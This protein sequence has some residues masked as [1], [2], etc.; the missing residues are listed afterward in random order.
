MNAKSLASAV[1]LVLA[2][3]PAVAEPLGTGD[4]EALLDK[5][6]KLRKL[7]ESEQ[8]GRHG[9][10]RT[11]F[12]AAMLSDEGALDLYL[13]CIERVQFDGEQ[14]KPQEF[15]DWKRAEKEKLAD[16]GLA[17]AL[18]HQLRWLALTLDAAEAGSD[19]VAVTA[20]A[21]KAVDAVF[22]DAALLGGQAGMLRGSVLDSVFAKGYAVKGLELKD[23]PLSPSNLGE[24]Y[25]TLIL[26]PL[27][28]PEKLSELRS[29]WMSWIGQ[30]VLAAEHWGAGKK[31][32]AAGRTPA[33]ERFRAEDYPEMVWAMEEDLFKA[34]DEHAAAIN[35]LNQL[36]SLAKDRRASDWAR[37]FEALLRGGGEE[38]GPVPAKN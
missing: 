33:V 3:A 13:N 23:W 20:E 7:A 18:R 38:A 31:P 6:E 8:Q 11:A 24:V 27:R 19:R 35:M 22:A 29:A 10:A 21:R 37:R 17:R 26:P 14:K 4:R 36:E 25:A 9:V 1:M 2:A 34:G 12:R 15:R 30:S 28:K 16:P 32:E 5:V